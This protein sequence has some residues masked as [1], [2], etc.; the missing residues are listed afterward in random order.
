MKFVEA[1]CEVLG[2]EREAVVGRELTKRFEEFVRAPLHMLADALNVVRG[3]VVIL[4][5]GQRFEDAPTEA[6]IESHL[7]AL[8]D[9]GEKP[10]Q[11]AKQV[12]KTLGCSRDEVYQLGLRLKDRTR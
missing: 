1:A 9:A 6:V 5:E 11:A 12:A 4:I 8:L 7:R 10:S 3:E 2:P